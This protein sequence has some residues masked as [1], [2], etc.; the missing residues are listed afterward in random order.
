MT[1][2][3]QH[4][5]Q[6]DWAGD[7]STLAAVWGLPTVAMLLALLLGPLWRAVAWIA[8]LAWMGGACVAT[9]RRC[10][11]THCRYTGPFFLGMGG[12]VAAPIAGLLPLGREPW[13][14]VRH[15]YC[16]RQCADL[17]GQRTCLRHI[18]RAWPGFLVT[19]GGGCEN[20]LSEGG[21]GSA[22]SWD[23]N[24]LACVLSFPN[25]RDRTALFAFPLPT[26][27]MTPTRIL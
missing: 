20:G 10:G 22:G 21:C 1:N 27:V 5:E 8:M 17:V 16:G 3:R 6:R 9:A 18:F 26:W 25:T 14:G 2:D 24:D 13:L 15:R 12:L 23:V 11:R 19:W 4:C 7:W